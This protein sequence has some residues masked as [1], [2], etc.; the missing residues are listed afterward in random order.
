MIQIIPHLWFEKD[1]K[2]AVSFYVDL[3][4]DSKINEIRPYKNPL[5]EETEIIHFELI[6]QKFEAINAGPDYKFNPSTS[7]MVECDTIERVDK[8]WKALSQDA[9]ILLPLKEYPYNEYYG[10]LVDRFGLSWQIMMRHNTKL[11]QRI[12]PCLLFSKNDVGNAYDAMMHYASIFKNAEILTIQEYESE[13]SLPTLGKISHALF[14]LNEYV[15]VTMDNNT[16]DDY[17][18]NSALSFIIYC[19]SQKEIDYYWRKLSENKR[20]N[21]IGWL[22]DQYG[23]TWR[24]LPKKLKQMMIE[25]TVEQQDRVIESLRK[26]KKV[27]IKEIEKAYQG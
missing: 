27:N 13:R 18:L 2:E 12:I 4:V 5:I 6:G 20:N 26:M 16:E 10:W 22:Q 14:H 8:I 23:V 17:Q 21:S 24:I 19:D 9:E 11:K 7:L 25:G 1:A 15:F 3:F